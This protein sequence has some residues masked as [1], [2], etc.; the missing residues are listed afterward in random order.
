MANILQHWQSAL[1]AVPGARRVSDAELAVPLHLST[2][3]LLLS[4]TLPADFPAAA[5]VLTVSP[6]VVHPM[7]EGNTLNWERAAGRDPWNPQASLLGPY[8]LQVV[9][10]LTS[11]PP[12]QATS[13]LVRRGSARDSTTP[14]ARRPASYM[15]SSSSN[16]GNALARPMS[17]LAL[18]NPSSSASTATSNDDK[19]WIQQLPD[20]LDG[21]TRLLGDDD[22][23]HVQL[24]QLDRVRA[25]TAARADLLESNTAAAQTV[26]D[27][28]LALASRLAAVRETAEKLAAAQ[29]RWRETA[30]EHAALAAG[31]YAPEKLVA[32]VA[33]V[34]A[35]ADAESEKLQAAFWAGSFTS[36]EGDDTDAFVRAY[37]ASRKRFHTR[38]C[39]LEVVARVG[40]A[41]AGSP[42]SAMPPANRPF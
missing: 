34:A 13:S 40:T 19:D 22:A 1:A 21:L 35:E 31:K 14:G 28:R 27:Q 8:L 5:P 18:Q 6:P 23:Q 38:S 41:R 11:R 4:V 10:A 39:R 24:A 30:A 36:P 3:P 16:A 9:Q 25:M 33:N 20:T 7:V 15:P 2:G 42:V 26:V 17:M 12:L 37:R 32:R 29:D